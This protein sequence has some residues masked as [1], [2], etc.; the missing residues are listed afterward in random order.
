ML[1]SYLSKCSAKIEK[2]APGPKGSG[3]KGFL[4]PLQ[5]SAQFLL[6]LN[7]LEEGFEVSFSE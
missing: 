6:A 4:L 3:E 5:V 1:M 7:G 2:S